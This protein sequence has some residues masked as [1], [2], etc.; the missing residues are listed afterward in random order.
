MERRLLS[1]GYIIIY[2]LKYTK[3]EYHHKNINSLLFKLKLQIIPKNVWMIIYD[4]YNNYLFIEQKNVFLH[5]KIKYMFSYINN[6]E[7]CEP[8]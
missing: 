1:V 7:I 4:I 2:K 3:L 5:K 6:I 8:E